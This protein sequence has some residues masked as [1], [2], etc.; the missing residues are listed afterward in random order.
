MTNKFI[1]IIK[2]IYN[3]IYSLLINLIFLLK[4]IHFK[5]KPIY[6]R[7]FI[8]II[9]PFLL[10]VLSQDLSLLE[11]LI[12][13]LDSGYSNI[14]WSLGS[15]QETPSNPNRKFSAGAIALWRDEYFDIL[16]TEGEQQNVPLRDEYFQT[17]LTWEPYN[18]AEHQQQEFVNPAQIYEEFFPPLATIVEPSNDGSIPSL[19]SIDTGKVQ[20]RVYSIDKRQVYTKVSSGK[21][22]RNSIKDNKIGI[23]INTPNSSIRKSKIKKEIVKNIIK[24]IHKNNSGNGQSRSGR[25]RRNPP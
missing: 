5:C 3:I 4:I 16:K 18:P 17:L 6:I 11:S 21:T 22:V 19:S 2:K 15:I 7:V 14:D 1:N 23:N 12:I 20:P 9:F 25:S 24:S 8:I 10:S 13:S